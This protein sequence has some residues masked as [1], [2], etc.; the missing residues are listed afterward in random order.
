M[1]S[2]ICDSAEQ[3]PRTRRSGGFGGLEVLGGVEGAGGAGGQAFVT[4]STW[5]SGSRP[6]VFRSNLVIANLKIA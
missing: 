5:S 1:R 2:V 4:S 3:N 6:G